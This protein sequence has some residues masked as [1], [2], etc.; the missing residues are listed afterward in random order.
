[1][2][3]I[4]TI[5]NVHTDDCGTPPVIERIP[6]DYVSYFENVHGEQWIFHYRRESNEITFYGGDCGWDEPMGV[7]EHGDKGFRVVRKR[8]RDGVIMNRPEE[9]W[10]AACVALAKEASR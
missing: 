8:D 2:T 1:M 5:E 4:L 3:A 6:G 9:L 10:A 7:E